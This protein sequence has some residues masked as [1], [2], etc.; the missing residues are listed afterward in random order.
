MVG[1]QTTQIPQAVFSHVPWT[2]NYYHAFAE[3]LVGMFMQSCQVFGA[4]NMTM[5]WTAPRLFRTEGTGGDVSWADRLPGVHQVAKCFSPQGAL[6]M[7]DSSIWEQVG[8][9]CQGPKGSGT[10][11]VSQAPGL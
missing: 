9:R 4:C 6:H 1:L 7:T 2:F 10:V 8:R 3:G 11:C 5:D